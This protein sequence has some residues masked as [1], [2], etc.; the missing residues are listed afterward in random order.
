MKEEA[1]RA[2]R[3]QIISRMGPCS[4]ALRTPWKRFTLIEPG[5]PIEQSSEAKGSEQRQAL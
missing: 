3:L 2:S 1:H 4:K 5:M